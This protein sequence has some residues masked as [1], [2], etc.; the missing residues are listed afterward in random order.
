MTMRYA[1][2][3]D[4]HGR[5]QKLQAVLADARTRG[6]NRIISLGD[7]G[8]SDCLSLLSQIGASAVFG[9]YEVSG[10]RRLEPAHRNWVRRWPPLLAQDGFLAVHAA[11]WWPDGVQTLEEFGDWI[12]ESDHLWR[13]LFPYLT[14]LDELWRALAEMEHAGSALL[15]HGHTHRQAVWQWRPEGRLQAVRTSTVSIKPDCRYII[16]VGSV[17]LPE[18]GG[19][20]TYTLYDTGAG[21]IELIRLDSHSHSSTAS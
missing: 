6:A 5:R 8:G 16:G 21:R 15:F 19:W 11:P 7:V 3:S 10:W 20:S 2:L 9:N 12:E 14:T 13:V 4:V 18:D 17:G 1:F